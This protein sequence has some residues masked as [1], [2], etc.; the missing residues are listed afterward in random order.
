M[1]SEYEIRLQETTL[2]SGKIIASDLNAIMSRL[3]DLS[4]RVSRWVADIEGS[5]RGPLA[6]ERSAQILVG[7][8]PGSTVLQ[9]ERG[10]HD[11]LDFDTPFEEDTN[12]RFWEVV[13]GIGTDVPPAD[14][15]ELVRESAVGL[16][17]ALQAAAPQVTVANPN[18]RAITFRPDQRSRETWNVKTRV[19]DEI[20]VTFT[21]RLDWADLPK[22]QLKITDDVGNRV[23]L[24]RV[25][26]TEELVRQLV[27][28]RVTATG[29]ATRNVAGQ[30]VS[31]KSPDIT[32][33]QVPDAWHLRSTPSWAPPIDYVGPDPDGGVEFDDDEWVTFM[34]AVKAA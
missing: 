14:A 33:A 1:A 3:Q 22:R 23:T 10:V 19:V 20:A 6:V 25:E 15:P 12:K 8:V 5:G 29:I 30:V 18:G 7:I 31:I 17:D 32:E 27:G 13:A 11:A 4:T 2:P 16:L 34:A 9:I 21:G 26:D 24:T 28:H